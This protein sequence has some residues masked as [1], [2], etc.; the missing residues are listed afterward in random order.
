METR[1]C[2]VGVAPDEGTCARLHA[3]VLEALDPRDWKLSA[4]ED[5]HV[6]LCFLGE[7]D[8]ERVPVLVE[9]LGI[10]L[11]GLGAP[12]LRLAGTGVFGA[13]R[14]PRVLWAGVDGAASELGRLGVLREATARAVEAAGLAWDRSGPFAPH[15]TVARPRRRARLPERFATLAF[16]L[17]WCPAA[18][19][20]HASVPDA[21]PHY[22]LLASFPLARP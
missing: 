22:P 7:I 8:A 13:T 4:A 14:E 18:V 5:Y 1:R 20:L 21:R 11:T 3:L 2:F 17:A 15:V 12:T 19:E 6:T 9:R 10:E 16:D